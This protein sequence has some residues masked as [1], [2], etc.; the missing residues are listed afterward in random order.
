MTWD[1]HSALGFWS[2][3]VV[4]MWSVSGLYLAEP[5]WFDGLLRLN[6]HD[7]FV[8]RALCSHTQL[9]V[10]RFSLTAELARAVMGLIPGLLAISAV[11]ICCRRMIWHKPSNPNTPRRQ[12]ASQFPTRSSPKHRDTSTRLG[13]EAQIVY[14]LGSLSTD[15]WHYAAH[16]FVS[17]RRWRCVSQPKRRRPVIGL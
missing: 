11:F 1:A 9:H 7:R 13:S 10:G 16:S 8:D 15:D 2:L 3:T 6:P 5:R 12:V 14:Y 4:T 17:G